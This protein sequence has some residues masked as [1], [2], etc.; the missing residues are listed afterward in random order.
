MVLPYLHYL[1]FVCGELIIHYLYRIL[2]RAIYIIPINYFPKNIVC[3][4]IVLN[5]LQHI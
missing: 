3:I 1:L 4:L 2:N 5:V